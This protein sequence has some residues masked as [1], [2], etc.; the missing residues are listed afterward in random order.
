MRNGCQ[1]EEVA[2]GKGRE[3]LDKDL[4][5]S[6]LLDH[7]EPSLSVIPHLEES[8]YAVGVCLSPPFQQSSAS[9]IRGRACW[10]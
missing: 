6:A 1:R 8:I 9:Y 5:V 7:W 4:S 2:G 10:I 3:D